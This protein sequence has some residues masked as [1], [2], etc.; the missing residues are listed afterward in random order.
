MTEEIIKMVDEISRMTH[1]ITKIALYC[2][3]ITDI[4]AK[5]LSEIS[6]MTEEITQ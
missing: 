3:K 4:A 2:S 6:I 1:K 5:W